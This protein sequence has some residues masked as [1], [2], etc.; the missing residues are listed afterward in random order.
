M[1]DNNMPWIRIDML[2]VRT[3]LG[4]YLRQW[5]Q[6]SLIY[7]VK[8]YHLKAS[9]DGVTHYYIDHNIVM[10]YLMNEAYS[11]YWLDNATD[12]RYWTIEPVFSE[13]FNLPFLGGDF[14]GYV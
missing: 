7:Y 1:T 13:Y 8:M 9:V 12:G 5:R 3:I 6:G 14:I 10:E 4:L 11:T 2:E